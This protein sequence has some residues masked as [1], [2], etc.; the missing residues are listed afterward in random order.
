MHY[1][2]TYFDQHF[3][4]RGLALYHS[5]RQHCPSFRLF[6]LCM[7]RASFDALSR[8]RLPEI[9]LVALEEFERGD[10]ELLQA[11]QHRTR[12]EYYFT[13]TPSLLLSI[14]TNFT[15][16]DLLTYL[17]ADLFF[18]ANPA[19]VYKEIADRSIAIIGHRFPSHLHALERCGIYNVGWLSFR[20][21]PDGLACLTWWR[22]RCIE[23]CHDRCENGRFA[24]QKYLDDWPRQF[25][26]VVVLQHKGANLAPWNMANYTI[27]RKGNGVWVDEDPL[28]FFHFHGLKQISKWVYNPNVAAYQVK[29]SA[30]MRRNIFGPYIRTLQD[31]KRQVLPRL[32]Q[33]PLLTD[34]RTSLTGSPTSREPMSLRSLVGGARR[35]LDVCRGILGRSYILAVR[36]YAI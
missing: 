11:K 29:A 10:T 9:H 34:I 15:E 13:C 35:W 26:D 23:W 1:F 27:H 32:P 17:D 25:Q 7:D 14:L 12:I 18:F 30:V 8:L 16:V 19:P 21:T 2:C 4:P 6:V 28:I 20:R 36:G 5:L 24:D 33:A 22:Q 3:L 31:M